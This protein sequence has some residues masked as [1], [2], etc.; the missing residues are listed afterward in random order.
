MKNELIIDLHG[1]IAQVVF[2]EDSKPLYAISI[3]PS[4]I[5]EAIEDW[6]RENIEWAKFFEGTPV[7]K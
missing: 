6:V 5:K 2:M 7:W 4:N 3:S 1:G